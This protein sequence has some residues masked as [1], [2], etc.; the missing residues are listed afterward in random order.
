MIELSEWVG[1]NDFPDRPWLVLGKGPSFSRRHEYDLSG[2]NLFGLNHV[3]REID[4]D[5]AHA[6]DIDVILS[7]GELLA[8]RCR[9]LIVPRTP[10]VEA[11]PGPYSIDDYVRRIPVLRRFEDEGRLVW[12]NAGTAPIAGPPVIPVR[13]FSS[14][15]ALG[16]LGVM[17]VRTVRSLGIDGGRYYSSAFADLSE[18]TLLSVG[19]SSFDLQFEGIDAAVQRHEIDYAPMAEP[20]RVFVG[21]DDSQLVAAAVLEHSI[22]KHAS[23]P[24]EFNLMQNLPIPTPKD[25]ENRP[26]TGFSFYRFVIPSL[27]GYQGRALYLDA[28]MQVFGDIAELW[29]LPFDNKKVLCT[30]QADAP[31]A[32]KDN[33]WF[34][35]GRQMSVM[36]L[37]C[38]SLRWDVDEIIEGLDEGLYSYAGLLFELELVPPQEI[39]ETIPSE[40]NSL[41][42]YEAGVTKL[43]HYTVGPMQPWRNDDNPLREIWDEGYR[44]ALRAGAIDPDIVERGIR[45]ELYKPSL[46]RHLHLSPIRRPVWKR[47]MGRGMRIAR[48]VRSKVRMQVGI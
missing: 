22:K 23:G 6:I 16:I 20:M 40:W 21:A 24:V 41:E 32:W 34:H 14:E 12:Y 10:H 37:D 48:R 27:C 29:R 35:P 26:R 25:P 9:W 8:E 4:V 11:R 7:L 39:G 5:I 38:Q 15:A 2:Y 36:M 33:S 45:Q 43:L 13:H 17:G 47:A 44:D 19:Q 28:D 31:D 18:R 42:H 30:Y 3:V 46:G 1:R